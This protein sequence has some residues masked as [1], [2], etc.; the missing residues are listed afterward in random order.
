MCPIQNH[1]EQT[2][3]G[4]GTLLGPVSTLEHREMQS[5]L[6]RKI[7]T[8][9][10]LFV[11]AVSLVAS[12]SS[13]SQTPRPTPAF[14]A[15]FRIPPLAPGPSFGSYS[16]PAPLPLFTNPTISPPPPASTC[17]TTPASSKV[18]KPLPIQGVKIP[19]LPPGGWQV[20]VSQW[21]SP[22]AAALADMGGIALK[23]WPEDWYKG[24]NKTTYAAKRGQRELIARGYAECVTAFSS[25]LQ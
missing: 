24:V 4:D 1:P 13:C 23:D 15:G 17:A 21:E 9:G 8:L 20:A 16:C 10:G 18:P 6:E 19:D 2:F 12:Q 22:D 25:Y 5:S 14:S 11:N 7:D 3:N